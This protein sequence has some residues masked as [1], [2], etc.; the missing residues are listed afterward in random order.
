MHFRCIRLIQLVGSHAVI[1]SK[2]LPRQRLSQMNSARSLYS[3]SSLGFRN[4]QNLCNMRY[5]LQKSFNYTSNVMFLLFFNSLKNIPEVLK[6]HSVKIV[7]NCVQ[8]CEYVLAHRIRRSHQMLCLYSTLWGEIPLYQFVRRLKAQLQKR[9]HLLLLGSGFVSAYDWN[10][11]RIPDED[12][13][14]YSAEMSLVEFLRDKRKACLKGNSRPADCTCSVCSATDSEW[15]SFVEEDDIVVWKREDINHRGQGLYCYKMYARYGDVTAY[16][17]LEAQVDLEYRQS[18]DTHAV[19][20]RLIDSEPATNSDV[21]YWET[22]WPK[23]FS[24]RDYVFKRRYRIDKKRNL[25]YLVNRI[26]EHPSCP[27]VPSK[28]RVSEYWSYMI[29]KPQTTFDKPGIEF[30]LTYFD[31]PGLNVPSSLTFWVTVSGMPDYLKKLRLAALGVAKR[32]GNAPSPLASRDSSVCAV[33][34]A[35]TLAHVQQVSSTATLLE[36]LRATLFLF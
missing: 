7:Q 25:I 36:S 24:N 29:I 26:T 8:S 16:D 14:K 32:R 28:Q 22:K 35:M 18:W 15:Q 9:K 23:L 33:E 3:T 17:F 30:S 1:P 5:Q 20:L 12:I 19:D 13:L 11:E 27:V 21:I 31:N 34:A 4:K 10:K 2:Q 6:R